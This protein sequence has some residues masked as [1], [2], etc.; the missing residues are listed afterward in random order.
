M[1]RGRECSESCI[2]YLA[3]E[4]VA[5]YRSQQAGGPPLA[6]A[7]EAI[8]LRVGRQLIE[9]YTK[10]KAPLLDQLEVGALV[11]TKLR[12]RVVGLWDRGAGGIHSHS[13]PYAPAGR[14][15][16]GQ[17]VARCCSQ[18]QRGPATGATAPLARP[19]PPRRL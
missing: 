10:D 11:P 6:A 7:I 14:R 19:R 18:G 12:V 16:A 2:D 15:L 13:T 3:L 1:T 5:H 4:L 8:G 17:R 9:R